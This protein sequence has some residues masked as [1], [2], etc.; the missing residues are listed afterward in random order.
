[1][2]F[3][4][5]LRV[6]SQVFFYKTTMNICIK[7]LN[8]YFRGTFYDLTFKWLAKTATVVNTLSR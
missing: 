2:F 5:F 6:F 7:G 8:G 3:F 1:M 4:F